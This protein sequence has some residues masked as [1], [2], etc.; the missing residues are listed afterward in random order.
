MKSIAGNKYSNIVEGYG[1]FSI[2]AA[3]QCPIRYPI[4]NNQCYCT[5]VEKNSPKKIP[6]EGAC[7]ETAY[8]ASCDINR[9]NKCSF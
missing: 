2:Y 9:Q 6:R 4:Y 5:E 8:C 3:L 7:I 1:A